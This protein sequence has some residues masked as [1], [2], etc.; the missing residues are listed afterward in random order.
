MYFHYL[1]LFITELTNVVKLYI[2]LNTWRFK[3][4]ASRILDICCLNVLLDSW[5]I[6]SWFIVFFTWMTAKQ[7]AVDRRYID[8]WLGRWVFFSWMH[9]LSDIP[10][11]FVKTDNISKL[12]EELKFLLTLYNLTL[13]TYILKVIVDYGN[14]SLTKS[15]HYTVG[16]RICVQTQMHAMRK[17]R[18]RKRISLTKARYKSKDLVRFESNQ[19]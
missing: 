19:W 6:K 7:I 16:I 14:M 10:V 15:T 18:A 3:V 11:F 13:K 17:K 9:N 5:N 12:S 8:V 1:R 2:W 4:W